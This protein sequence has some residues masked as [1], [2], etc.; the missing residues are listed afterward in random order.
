LSDTQNTS[1]SGRPTNRSFSKPVKI[2][3]EYTVD[4][5]DTGRSGD[6]V[7]RIGGLVIFVKKRKTGDKNVKIRL[8]LLVAD[9]PMQ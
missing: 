5:T 6:G 1:D 4:I 2:G 3:N 9:L 7:T 8:V